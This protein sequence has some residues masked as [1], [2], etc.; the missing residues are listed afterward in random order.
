VQYDAIVWAFNRSRAT[1]SKALLRPLAVV[2][3]HDRW[4]SLGIYAALIGGFGALRLFGEQVIDDRA[5]VLL[6]A[7]VTTSTILHYYFDGFIWKVSE[8]KTQVD[9]AIAAGHELEPPKQTSLRLA[10]AGGWALFGAMIVV[11][12]GWE[13]Q[14][15]SVTV[16][17]RDTLARL[18]ALTPD[19]PELQ[20]RASEAALAANEIDRAVDAAQHAVRLRPYSQ[21]AYSRLGVAELEAGK[22]QAAADAFRRARQLAP[23]LWQNHSNLAIA[24]SRLGHWDEA[25]KEFAA[26]SQ[27]KHEPAPLEAA[28]ARSCAW[29]GDHAGAIEHGRSALAID[30][31]DSDTRAT[32]VEAFTQ[33]DQIDE[34]QRLAEE[35]IALD[36]QTWR[37]VFLLGNLQTA[38]GAHPEAARSYRRVLDLRPNFAPALANLASVQWLQGDVLHARKAYERAL[39]IEPN[40]AALHTNLGMLLSELGE[41]AAAQEHL[42]RAQELSSVPPPQ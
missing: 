40:D 39:T 36:P 8:R 37:L 41:A 24:L 13:Y 34:A 21:Q 10:H 22:W 27:L 23:G 29:R 7:I 1:K 9:L 6:L 35:G 28:W 11:F 16:E 14:H 4:A 25:D 15:R 32:L 20:W 17:G 30:P 18:V 3:G 19:L 31:A 2:F 38:R 42:R 26:A 12:L 33:T 5:Q